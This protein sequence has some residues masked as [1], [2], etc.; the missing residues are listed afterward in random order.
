M[1]K[2]ISIIVPVYFNEG[3]LKLLFKEF[4]KVSEKNPEYDFE[5]IFVDDYSEDNSFPVLLQIYNENPDKI[6]VIRLSKNYGSN[7]ALLAGLKKSKGDCAVFISADLQDPPELINEMIEEWEKGYESI[8]AVRNSRKDNFISKIFSNIYYYLF[9]KFALKDMPEGGFDFCLIDKKII[10]VLCEMEEKNSYIMGQVLWTGFKK[11]C[12][13]YDRKKRQ[14]GK[15]KWTITKKI[16]YFIDAFISFSYLPIRIASVIGFIVSAIGFIY[17]LFLIYDRIVNNNLLHGITALIVI[18]LFIGGI[19][20]IILGIF[21]EYLWRIL[22]ESRKR[23]LYI[24]D[25]YYEKS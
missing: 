23:P 7:I 9:R 20:L 18:I 4:K 21:G 22:E 11:K 6:K 19:Q 16:K 1:K 15:S 5:Y 12:I 2:L 10:E 25:K 24:I 8:L 13:K 14:Y 17:A 3:S